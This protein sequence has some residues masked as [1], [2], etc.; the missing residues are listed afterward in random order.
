MYTFKPDFF[1]VASIS[2]RFTDREIE[3]EPMLYSASRLFAETHGGP[4]TQ[5]IMRMMPIDAFF[6]GPDRHLVIDSRSHM[7]MP[8]M[9]PAIPGWHGDAWPRGENGQPDPSNVK[10]KR[11]VRHWTAIVGDCSL[12][13]FLVDEHAVSVSLD[14]SEFWACVSRRVGSYMTLAKQEPY[15][16]VEFGPDQLHRA[17]PATHR[18]WRF[19]LRLSHLPGKPHNKI[20]KQSQV[21]CTEHG[22]W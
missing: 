5:A 14:S 4:I 20:R 9:Y 15:S 7:L 17:S 6:L 13:E 11:H 16:I 19:W 22:G 12:T 18:G 1:H 2:E 10:D 21:Y 8:G 3:A